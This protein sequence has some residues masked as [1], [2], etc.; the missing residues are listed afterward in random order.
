MRDALR[1]PV[2]TACFLSA[3]LAAC[4]VGGGHDP[5]R[6]PGDGLNRHVPDNYGRA[7]AA[8]RRDGLEPGTPD[9]EACVRERALDRAGRFP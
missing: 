2:M 8:C 6:N 5:V 1:R 9:Y 7:A 3:L 4:Q